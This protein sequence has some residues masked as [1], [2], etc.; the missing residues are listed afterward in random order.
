MD[1]IE[2]LQTQHAEAESLFEKLADEK[3]E[4]DWRDLLGR[5]VDRLT[6]HAR[7]E[8][9]FFYPALTEIPD[10]AA[11]AVHAGDEHRKID[12]QLNRLREP[13]VDV[14]GLRVGLSELRRIVEHHLA[15]EEG[16]LM[17]QARRLGALRLRDLARKME[18][19]MQFGTVE[20]RKAAGARG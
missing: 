8:E 17:P 16:E 2:L 19:R 20:H 9:E 11:Q 1:A 3:D 18:M 14:R 15:E 12:A 6:V 5:L 7:L 13:K 10:A 4:A